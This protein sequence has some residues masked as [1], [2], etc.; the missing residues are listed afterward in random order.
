MTD[1][2]QLVVCTGERMETL[3]GKL[4]SKVGTQTTTFEPM[5]AKGLSNE[6]RCYSN[7][8]CNYWKWVQ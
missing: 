3:V 5:H 2:L 7:F 1:S 8:E 4:Y 6:F